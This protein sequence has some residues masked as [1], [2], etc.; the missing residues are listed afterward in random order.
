[1]RTEGG[2]PFIIGVETT[3]RALTVMRECALATKAAWT[4]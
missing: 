4:A 1:M 3:Q 2:N